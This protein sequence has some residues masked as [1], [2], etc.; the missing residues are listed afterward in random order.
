MKRSY[1]FRFSAA[2]IFIALICT[3]SS[4]WELKMDQASIEKALQQ[5]NAVLDNEG[6]TPCLALSGRA[7][8]SV[9]LNPADFAGKTVVLNCE[10]RTEGISVNQ[11][12]KNSHGFKAQLYILRRNGKKNY[13]HKIPVQGTC[14]WST[15]KQKISVSISG[16]PA[17]HQQAHSCETAEMKRNL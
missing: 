15:I 7:V 4:A 11:E 12:K 2:W 8:W 17:C 3:V 16:W 13:A 1:C 14:N 10:Y 6:K 5:R 9:K